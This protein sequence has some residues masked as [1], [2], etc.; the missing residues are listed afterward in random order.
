MKQ[1]KV[2]VML[3]ALFLITVYGSSTM[4]A[5]KPVAIVNG[6]GISAA[7]FE[8]TVKANVDKGQKDTPELRNAIKEELISR[9]LVA[10]DTQKKGL[11]K[12]PEA[13][14][15]LAQIRQN[16]LIELNMADFMKKNPVTEAELK[17]EYDRQIGLLGEPGKIQEY[18]ISQI[19]TQTQP[20]AKAALARIQKGE[21][22]AK[23]AKEVSIN[24]SKEGGGSLGWVLPGQI[25]PSIGNV[26]V[27]L[28]KGGITAQP[29]E[30]PYGWNIIKVDD[31]RAF[32]PPSLEQ[33]KEQVQLAVLQA[34]KAAYIKKIRDA[35]KITQ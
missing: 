3:I 28:D 1:I 14:E 34:K 19:V 26:I 31:K 10:Q 21:A 12:T 30:T 22:F 23:V 18:Q 17:A 2:S 11:D 25:L 8:K 20:D 15:Q 7:L 29:I 6:V 32:T 9:E 24:P 33:A 27:N 16:F 4:A 35:A 5:D 13:Q